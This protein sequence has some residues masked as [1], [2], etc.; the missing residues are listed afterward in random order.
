[1]HFVSF[2]FFIIFFAM[3]GTQNCVS[4]AAIFISLTSQLLV[5]LCGNDW[6]FIL[7]AALVRSYLFGTFKHFTRSLTSVE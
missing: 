5:I 3:L 6:I 1:M 2:S 7:L 4:G